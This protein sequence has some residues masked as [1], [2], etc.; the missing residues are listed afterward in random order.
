[1]PVV[2]DAAQRRDFSREL[3]SPSSL[4]EATRRDLEESTRQ[5]PKIAKRLPLN[6]ASSTSLPVA[7][8]LSLAK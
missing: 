4:F 7:A 3:V 5:Y 2:G 6:Q 8:S 1:M